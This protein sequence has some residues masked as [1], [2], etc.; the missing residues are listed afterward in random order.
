MKIRLITNYERFDADYKE[1]IRAFAPHLE[2]DDAGKELRLIGT[3][4]GAWEHQF[5]IIRF[6]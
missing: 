6:N 2:L 5:T 1:L 3:Q 4:V